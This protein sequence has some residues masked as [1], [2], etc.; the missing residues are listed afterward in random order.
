[1]IVQADTRQQR[2]IRTSG[3]TVDPSGG[4]EGTR[5]AWPGRREKSRE[6]SISPTAPPRNPEAGVKIEGPEELEDAGEE[7]Q[8]SPKISDKEEDPLPPPKISAG[9]E[10]LFDALL[11]VARG[12]PFSS[13]IHHIHEAVL[14]APLKSFSS[15]GV[16]P[17]GGG[18]STNSLDWAELVSCTCGNH[19]NNSVLQSSF[20][21]R[22]GEKDVE[23]SRL[24]DNATERCTF[25]LETE[26]ERTGNLPLIGCLPVKAVPL[27]KVRLYCLSIVVACKDRMLSIWYY[28]RL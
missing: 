28:R 16:S 12:I 22:E 27:M 15:S 14:W 1:V 4:G 25:Y 20:D 17:G 8:A 2:L 21:K 10:A 13:L 5:E 9:N 19:T 24:Q 6:T 26:S 23:S 11:M 18:G 3:P 7:T